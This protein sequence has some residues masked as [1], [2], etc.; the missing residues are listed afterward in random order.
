MRTARALLITCLLIG[1]A[2]A[3]ERGPV[4]VDRIVWERLDLMP[5]AQ[6]EK[7]KLRA[8]TTS[9]A[10][11]TIGTQVFQFANL[12]QRRLEA[13][14]H[15][16]PGEELTGAS[17]ADMNDDGVKEVLLRFSPPRNQKVVRLVVFAYARVARRYVKIFEQGPSPGLRAR[18]VPLVV[19][20]DL[21]EN[22]IAI[23]RLADD[24]Y[25]ALATTTYSFK[26]ERLHVVSRSAPGR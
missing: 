14:V 15:D 11:V 21:H 17:V 19:T 25:T 22:G 12:W 23:D 24:G 6:P 13:L 2:R 20:R 26:G 3:G 8:L 16:A 4:P 5:I 9:R 7:V 1:P 18:W 10:G